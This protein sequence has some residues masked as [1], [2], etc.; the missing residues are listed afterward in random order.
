MKPNV[1][2]LGITKDV[3]LHTHGCGIMQG[4]HFSRPM[5]DE[6]FEALLVNRVETV[7]SGR[8]Q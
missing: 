4:Y 1:H 7:S 5:A 6:D 8:P 2:P 3:G